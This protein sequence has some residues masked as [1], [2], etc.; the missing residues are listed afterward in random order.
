MTLFKDTIQIITVKKKEKKS[1]EGREI[2]MFLV[3]F[4]TLQGVGHYTQI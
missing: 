2:F 1:L 4:I 3:S